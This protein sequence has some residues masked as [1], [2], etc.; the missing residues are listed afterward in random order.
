MACENSL[1]SIWPDDLGFVVPASG[2]TYISDGGQIIVRPDS[3]SG[4][5]VRVNRNNLS[6]DKGEQVVG[7]PYFTHDETNNFINL[8]NDAVT[9]DKFMIQAYKPVS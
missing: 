4:W 7:D 3:F 5:K 9:G 2:G 6:L 8:S 1:G